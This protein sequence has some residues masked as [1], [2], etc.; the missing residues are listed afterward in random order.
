ME[1]IIKQSFNFAQIKL[2]KNYSDRTIQSVLYSADR[3]TDI[4][5]QE[6]LMPATEPDEF[7]RRFSSL[8]ESAL[9]EPSKIITIKH[10]VP[11][12]IES[13]VY[14]LRLY[15]KEKRKF[16]YMTEPVI[17]KNGG[18]VKYLEERT[19]RPYQVVK[20][21]NTKVTK[22]NDY[23]ETIK[24]SQIKRHYNNPF[25][26]IKIFQ[27][28]RWIKKEDNKITIK[29]FWHERTRNVNCIY[30]VKSLKSITIT[31]DLLTGNFRIIKYNHVRKASHKTFFANSFYSLG[32]ALLEFYQ[33]RNKMESSAF[34]PMYLS[35]FDT[36]KFHSYL[37]SALDIDKT[38][39]V[40]EPEFVVKNLINQFVFRFIE[41][42][43]IKA[44]DNFIRF[45]LY[46]YPTERYLKK[47][48]RK[49]IAA[50][51]DR[52]G[53]KSKITIKLLHEHPYIDMTML[54][55]LCRLFGKDYPKYIGNIS[56]DFFDK[57]M[58]L[59]KERE[60]FAKNGIL[61]REEVHPIYDEI[62]E[63]EKECMAKIINDIC[64]PNSYF[65]HLRDLANTTAPLDVV[66][67]FYDH[68]RMLKKIREYYPDMKLTSITY[69]TFLINHGEVAKIERS[70][71]R[72]W[73]VHFLFDDQI[74]SE[75]EKPI[76]L[77]ELP[78]VKADDSSYFNESSIMVKVMYYP[79][80]LK[81]T[82]DYLEEGS[83]MG[84]CVGGY[85][86][87]GGSMIISL[88]NGYERVTNEFDVESGECVQS[89]YFCNVDP[90]EKFR[91]PLEILKLRV[92]KSRGMLEALE[93]VKT[94]LVING[95]PVKEEGHALWDP[96]NNRPMRLWHPPAVLP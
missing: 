59:K 6:S 19:G 69:N 93:I 88:R 54:V 72:G 61:N 8:K 51:L 79:V 34:L 90:P 78:E 64:E 68:F 17:D 82:E 20:I 50:V 75:I 94:P 92:R 56:G 76:E 1:E 62:S 74:V 28:E 43:K 81:A 63:S 73:S 16:F 22:D 41:L 21:I 66:N 37:Q 25:A 5:Q 47:N 45:L 39:L 26:S 35:E 84:H 52:F 40:G 60:E 42:R 77:I 86:D 57:F 80:I 33:P 15:P 87:R 30:F 2:F 49:L 36:E 3:K 32:Q 95:V 44:P 11:T 23:F 58:L 53:I 29:F 7:L 48:D 70:I 96:F 55:D 24:D 10:I 4:N 65:R 85:D 12:R 38:P 71:Q 18:I 46:Y 31:F 13:A 83:V 27:I 91:K 67:M 89:R 9:I 14:D